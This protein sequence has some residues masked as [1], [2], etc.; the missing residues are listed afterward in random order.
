MQIT[1]V[2]DVTVAIQYFTSEMHSR[3]LPCWWEACQLGGCHLAARHSPRQ[4]GV[5]VGGCLLGCEAVYS[6]WSA[7]RNWRQES[8]F[9]RTRRGVKG[10]CGEERGYF[11]SYKR[12]DWWGLQLSFVTWCN[13]QTIHLIMCLAASSSLEFFGSHKVLA[14]P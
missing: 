1:F 12:M 2:K 5:M 8:R 3:E 6:N 10:G 13:Q 9:L 4:P 11:L 14:S 7:R